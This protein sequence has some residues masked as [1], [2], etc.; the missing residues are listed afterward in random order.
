MRALKG[1]VTK[2]IGVVLE[3]ICELAKMVF[4]VV[5]SLLK[6]KSRHHTTRVLLF[7]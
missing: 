1:A 7:Y 6:I 2:R 5:R 3:N 4:E